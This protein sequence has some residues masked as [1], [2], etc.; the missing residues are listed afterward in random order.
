LSGTP[1]ADQVNE[2]QGQV[3]DRA[4]I[5][6]ALAR[7]ARPP[8]RRRV[9][10]AQRPRDARRPGCGFTPAGLR[11]GWAFL[12]TD[13]NGRGFLLNVQIWVCAFFQRGNAS[14]CLTPFRVRLV[15]W[16]LGKTGANFFVT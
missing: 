2:L 10:V 5:G 16:I 15:R 3:R 8:A 11:P 13:E 9:P 6:I 14:V 12:C 1:R 7:H 4:P